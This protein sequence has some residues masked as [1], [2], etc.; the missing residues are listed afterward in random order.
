VVTAQTCAVTRTR[1]SY[2]ARRVGA[3]GRAWFAVLQPEWGDMDN[4]VDIAGL[5]KKRDTFVLDVERLAVPAGHLVSIVGQHGSGKSTLLSLIGGFLHR[6]S[7]SISVSGRPVETHQPTTD[8][9]PPRS[10]CR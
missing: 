2:G 5:R 6:D 7:G 8:S 10:L 3:A 1:A 4:C 9:V